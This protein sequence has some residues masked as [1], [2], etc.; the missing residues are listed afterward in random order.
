MLQ[1][2]QERVIAERDELQERI[3]R[4]SEFLDTEIFQDLPPGS[5]NLMMDQFSV[6]LRYRGI[7]NQRIA[8]FEE[9]N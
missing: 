6:M 9:S 2:Y 1:P 3:G 7:L 5:Q 4:L 8:L